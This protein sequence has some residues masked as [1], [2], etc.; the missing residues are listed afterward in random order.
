M[1]NNDSPEVLVGLIEEN[2]AEFLLALGG[3]AEAEERC[4]SGLHWII[5]NCLIDYHN[6]VVRAS[7]EPEAADEAIVASIAAFRRHDVSESWHVGPAMRPSDLG[8]RLVRHGFSY[9]GDD[10][11]MAMA[12]DRLPERIATP[13][14]L[15]IERV[16]TEPALNVWVET[17]G[18]AFGEG[19]IEDRWVG[20]MYRRIGLA[21][22]RP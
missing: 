17:L 5:G 8:E 15:V 4:E 1:R 20:E 16:Q 18:Q 13:P 22:D 7:L 2:G 21:D 11:G 6:A 19:E 14:G 12:L 10:I 9:A 3:A